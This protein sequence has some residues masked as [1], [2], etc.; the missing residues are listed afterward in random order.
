MQKK[1]ESEAP[2]N[3]LT[4]PMVLII[5]GLFTLM[6]SVVT[7]PSL[8]DKTKREKDE[9]EVALLEARDQI[10]RFEKIANKIPTDL[11]TLPAKLTMDD[12]EFV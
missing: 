5:L 4:C 6:L 2:R 12:I 11:L 9:F 8:L 1:V 7:P 10:A 3:F